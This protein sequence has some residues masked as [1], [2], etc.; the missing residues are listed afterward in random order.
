M[1]D[2]ISVPDLQAWIEA[3]GN[4]YRF[5]PSMDELATK[6]ETATE[7]RVRLLEWHVEECQERGKRGAKKRVY[8]RE[9]KTR[10]TADYRNICRDISEG[11]KARATARRAGA[12]VPT[13]PGTPFAR[14]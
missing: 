4:G 14:R 12:V 11:E 7:R 9:K 13:L 8:E 2:L 10:P 5:N 6:P 3:T 1:R